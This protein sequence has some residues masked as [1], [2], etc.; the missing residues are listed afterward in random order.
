MTDKRVT[1][2]LKKM[3][4]CAENVFKGVNGLQLDPNIEDFIAILIQLAD[5]DSKKNY[6]NSTLPPAFKNKVEKFL[7]GNKVSELKRLNE[8]IK[9]QKRNKEDFSAPAKKAVDI[10]REIINDLENS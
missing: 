10:M 3:N 9:Q 7:H 4:A 1:N 2:L 6:Y 5:I 8:Q